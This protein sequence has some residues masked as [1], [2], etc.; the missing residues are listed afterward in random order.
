[1]DDL[2]YRDPTGFKAFID[3]NRCISF[4]ATPHDGDPKGMEVE[5]LQVFKVK[6]YDY[7]LGDVVVKQQ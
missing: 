7:S 2:I 3:G 5:T 6:E 4:T 1:V